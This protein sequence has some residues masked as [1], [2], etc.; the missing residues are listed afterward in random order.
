MTWWRVS[1]HPVRIGRV[2]ERL[3]YHDAFLRTF[4]ARVTRLDL[5]GVVLDRTVFYPT[6]GGQPHDTGQLGGVQV[7][8]VFETE[9]GEIV[10]ALDGPAPAQVGQ[11]VRGEIDWPRR[12]D[13]IQQHS[14]QHLLSAVFIRLFNFPTVSFHLGAEISTI[15]LAAPAV[16]PEQAQQAEALS[17][18]IIFEDRPLRVF[19]ATPEEAKSLPLRKDV[20]REGE[21]RLVEIPDLDLT[22]CGGTHVARTGQIGAVLVRKT[23]KSRQGV[24]VEFVCG[25]RAVRLA[26]LDYA[27]LAEAASL[28]TTHPHQ[29]S[30]VVRKQA[31]ELKAAEKERQ[32]LLQT[33]AAYEA[34]ELFAAA[35]E[36]NG[37][38]QLVKLFEAA[39]PGYVRS[40]AGQFA[41]QGGAGSGARAVFAIQ[42]PPTLVLA[43]TRGLPADLGALVKKLAAEHGLRG[44]G[45][46]DA[47]QAGAPDAAA[48]E[49]ALEALRREL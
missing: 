43:Q 19:F 39:D 40:L 44:G 28:L 48:V 41:A 3:Y 13:H 42:Q 4:E 2:S 9:Q 26:R 17:N 38:R 1:Q 32:K 8:D 11:T 15:D 23:E 27:V 7:V 49:R 12:A 14:G 24:R 33:L 45:S 29:L 5:K 22:A 6:G 20:A 25:L 34:R 10:H 31:E 21:L 16:S 36:A 18:E 35:P 30:A 47:A 37:V 46:R